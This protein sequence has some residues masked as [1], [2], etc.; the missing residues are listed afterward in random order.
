MTSAIV[1]L[2]IIGAVSGLCGVFTAN[3]PGRYQYA[4]LAVMAVC[5]ALAGTAVMTG[6]TQ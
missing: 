3:R 2:L 4:L 5:I 1:P 6:P